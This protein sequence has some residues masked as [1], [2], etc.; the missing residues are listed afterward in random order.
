MY[1]YEHLLVKKKWFSQ[2]HSE[3]I[4]STVSTPTQTRLLVIRLTKKVAS[5]S[6]DRAGLAVIVVGEVQKSA[7]HCMFQTTGHNK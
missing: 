1:I 7:K 2:E 4:K 5:F 3:N 6:P